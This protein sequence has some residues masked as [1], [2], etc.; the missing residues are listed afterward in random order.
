MSLDFK[1]DFRP[2]AFDGFFRDETFRD[3]F[4]YRNSPQNIRRFPFPFDRDDYM[5]SVN[6]EPHVPGRKGTAFEHILDVDEHYVAE[7]IDR[8]KVLADDPLRCQ[9]LPHMTLAGWDLLELIMEA[10]ARDYPQWFSLT[11]DGN[12]WHWINRPLGIDHAVHLPRR[13]DA[14]LWPVRIHHAADPG[15]FQ[16]AGRTRRNDL[17]MDAG[18][19]HQSGGLVAGF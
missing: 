17:W 5:Y 7:M 13:I 14:A 18:H 8:A 12:R 11:K 4:T 19:G 16:P 9:S 15:R 1:P 10:K 6:M 2:G 3:D